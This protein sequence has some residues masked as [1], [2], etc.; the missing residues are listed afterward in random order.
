MLAAYINDVMFRQVQRG[1]PSLLTDQS[2]AAIPKVQKILRCKEGNIAGPLERIMSSELL[3][4]Y[5]PLRKY[6]DYVAGTQG[7]C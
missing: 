1:D 2:D 7:R 6:P 5:T 3:A 4:M